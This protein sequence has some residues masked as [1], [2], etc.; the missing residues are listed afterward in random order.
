MTRERGAGELQRSR[1][2]HAGSEHDAN[3]LRVGQRSGALRGEAL[4]GTFGD[5]AS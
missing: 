5:P 3:Q 1:A 2:T 4:A